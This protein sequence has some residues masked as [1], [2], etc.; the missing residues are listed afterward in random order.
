M[1]AAKCGCLA[2]AN[3]ADWPMQLGQHPAHSRGVERGKQYPMSGRQ[4]SGRV[5]ERL[6][7]EDLAARES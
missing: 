5:R 3:L 2:A 7:S 6:T 1:A 4:Q